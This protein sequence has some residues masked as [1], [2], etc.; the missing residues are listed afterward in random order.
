MTARQDQK[1]VSIVLLAL[2]ES[3]PAGLYGLYEMFAAVGVTW[4]ELT[5]EVTGTRRIE[6]RIVASG[7][8]P[9]ST[10]VGLPITPHA[11][12]RDVASCDVV[13][14]TDLAITLDTDP[15]GCWPAECAWLRE[16]ARR[17][18]IICSV[19]TGTIL[20]AEAGLLDGLDA[21]TH[22]C[23]VG[24]LQSFYPTVR[25]RPERILCPDGPEHRMVTGGGASSWEDLALY[26]IARFC[27]EAEALRIAKIFVLGDR[28]EGQ[29]P[30]SALGRPR[31]HAD[32]AI[33]RCQQWLADHYSGPHPVA[34]MVARSGLPERT[35]KRRFKAATGYAPVEYV[36]A[37][38][39]EEAKQL[40]ETTDF[41]TD[42][43]A[44][45]VGYEDPAFFRRLF[46]RRTGVTPARYRQRVQVIT[47][48]APPAESVAP[49]RL[50]VS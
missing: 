2:P 26:L 27:G 32:A 41:P 4:A 35:F 19:C 10:A 31:S 34:R 21:T 42:V 3:T 45:T 7:G 9:F 50:S 16:Q 8:A 39:I 49:H 6:P 18:A 47:H 23:A 12:L 13:I 48:L 11:D 17:G 38:R 37:L 14:V 28:S 15:R 25:P 46:K 43:I 29:L 40:L 1:P 5:G 20:L 24:V 22:W 30:F 33:E 36:Q 44:S